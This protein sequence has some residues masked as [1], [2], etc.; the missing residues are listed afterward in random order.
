MTKITEQLRLKNKTYLMPFQK[1]II[2]TNTAVQLLFRDLQTRF[3][4]S[5]LLTYPLNQDVL[6]HFFSVIRAK[7]GLHDHPDAIEFK[8]R[9]RDYLLGKKRSNPKP[10]KQTNLCDCQSGRGYRYHLTLNR[11]NKPTFVT[12]NLAEVID[13]TVST[14]R[15]ASWVKQWRVSDEPSLSDHRYVRFNIEV[16]QIS[17]IRYHRYE[18]NPF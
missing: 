18:L 14:P 9:L 10:W 16:P 7:G 6:E 3:Q 4:F 2:M 17:I 13:I 15:L 8:Y 5:Y 1:G 11:G 12:A